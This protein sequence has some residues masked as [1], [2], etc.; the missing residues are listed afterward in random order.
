VR[1]K[2]RYVYG[3]HLEQVDGHPLTKGLVK[4]DLETRSVQRHRLSPG[5]SVAGEAVFVP[6]SPDS[7]EEAGYLLCFIHDEVE[8]RSEFAV[9]DACAL[10]AGPIAQ[11]LI[12]QRVPYG[13]HAIWVA[14]RSVVKRQ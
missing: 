4:V 3:L 11:V 1:Q 5:R 8:A 14:H 10:E 6:R 13:F 9:F 12:P 7:P 2:I